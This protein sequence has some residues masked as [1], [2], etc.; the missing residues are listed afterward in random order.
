MKNVIS[1]ALM[2][3]LSV[4]SLYA[5][6]RPVKMTFS[7]TSGPTL[8]NLQY[9]GTVATSEYNFAGNGALGAF[10]F[11]TYS[12]SGPSPQPPSSCLG[13]TQVSGTVLG[14]GG[15]LR[16]QDESLLI[17]T[18]TEGTDCI[19]F[20]PPAQAHCIRTFEITGGTGRFK[21]AK[22]KLTFDEILQ[23]ALFDAANTPVFFSATGTV[24]GTIS[25]VKLPDDRWDNQ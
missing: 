3:S 20:A 11:R 21:D 12:A 23:P 19:D 10:T 5:H 9:P 16:A 13:P 24:T 17:L 7:G 15:V 8:I 1:L 4:A 6:E 22:G 18:L 25:G 2:L 14:G